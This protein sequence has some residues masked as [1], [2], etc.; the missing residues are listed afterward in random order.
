M[1]HKSE[2]GNDEFE[3]EDDYDDYML[4]ERDQEDQEESDEGIIYNHF[5]KHL[6]D[7]EDH[8]LTISK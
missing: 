4:Y 3:F 5:L 2:Y 8:I 1:S 7:F 6:I